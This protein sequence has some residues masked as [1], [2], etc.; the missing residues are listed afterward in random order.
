MAW[1]IGSSELSSFPFLLAGAPFSLGIV[2][3]TLVFFSSS[4]GNVFLTPPLGV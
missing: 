1:S 3:L 4:P 2:S